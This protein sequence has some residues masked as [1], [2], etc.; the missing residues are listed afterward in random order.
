MVDATTINF[1]S[2]F[3][4]VILGIILTQLMADVS[5][6]LHKIVVSVMAILAVMGSLATGGQ[7]MIPA[8]FSALIVGYVAGVT[9]ETNGA[10][11][12]LRAQLAKKE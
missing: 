3:V 9:F 8:F 7:V 10:M 4:G 5:P 12:Q 1:V 11:V 2:V 6:I